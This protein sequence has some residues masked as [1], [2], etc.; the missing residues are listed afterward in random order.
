MEGGDEA[1]GATAG[2]IPG[3][4]PDGFDTP[5][6][7]PAASRPG[8]A[9]PRRRRRAPAACG[10]FAQ[11]WFL[12]HKSYVGNIIDAHPRVGA[13]RGGGGGP[14]ERARRERARPRRRPAGRARGPGAARGPRPISGRARA[15]ARAGR[16]GR[17]RGR[18]AGNADCRGRSSTD[19]FEANPREG[20]AETASSRCPTGSG[21]TPLPVR[22]P[23]FS[24]RLI[25]HD[26]SR[27]LRR[28]AWVPRLAA[29][30][31]GP[32]EKSSTSTDAFIR[33]NRRRNLPAR[34]GA[35]LAGPIRPRGVGA[36]GR[37]PVARAAIARVRSGR[38]RGR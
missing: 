9:P 19:I 28:T 18:R 16:A 21:L 4:A 2:R 8:A 36:G 7:W 34:P 32:A 26:G 20:A 11:K 31:T 24:G 14:R 38:S 30:D 12:N 35:A 1:G 25:D 27:G 13:C 29:R 3:V 6:R 23:S 37:H 10:I 15:R 17:G 33:G 22:R 5:G